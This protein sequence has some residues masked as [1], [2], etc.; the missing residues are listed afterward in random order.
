[1]GAFPQTPMLPPEVR[2]QAAPPMPVMMQMG[3]AAAAAPPSPA[4]TIGMLEGKLGELKV[5]VQDTLPLINQ[6]QPSLKA[7]M[8]PLLN[9][10]QAFEAEVAKLKERTTQPSPALPPSPETMTPAAAA[11]PPSV[12]P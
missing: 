8:V 9:I 3:Q 10:G 4:D 12:G 7:F 5:W 2:Q 11:V 1:V 6:V